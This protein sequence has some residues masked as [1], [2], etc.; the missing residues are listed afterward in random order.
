MGGDKRDAGQT[1]RRGQTRELLPQEN[2]TVKWFV[3]RRV[4]RELLVEHS[5]KLGTPTPDGTSD[6]AFEN[7][8]NSWAGANVDAPGK[9]G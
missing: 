8:I 3:A 7:E 5:R 9:G 6:A 4:K 2:K 1:S